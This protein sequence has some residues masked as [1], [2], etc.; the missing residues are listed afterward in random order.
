MKLFLSAQCRSLVGM[1]DHTHGYHIQRRANGFYAKRNT[2]GF[3]PPDGHWR[4]ILA[5]AEMAKQK[6]YLV[7]I[8]VAKKELREALEEARH[9]QAARHLQ[10]ELYDARDVLNLKTLFGL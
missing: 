3:V 10:K 4:F 9:W 1:L 2:R 7:N 8:R 6:L 5:C